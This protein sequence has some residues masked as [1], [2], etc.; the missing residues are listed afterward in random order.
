MGGTGLEPVTPSLSIW[1]RRS[2]QFARVRSGGMLSGIHSATERLSER[3][4]TLILAILATRP[5][6]RGSCS[7][8]KY[9]LGSGERISNRRSFQ[10]E[11]VTE[12]EA[13]HTKA[14]SY[15]SRSVTMSS[16]ICRHSL[17]I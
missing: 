4:R 12:H 8:S 17:Q 15:A 13:G 2:R 11:R 3:E 7:F 16:Q 6:P 10:R 14:V 5:S 9:K 1:C